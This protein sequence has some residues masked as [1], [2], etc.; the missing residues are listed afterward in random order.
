MVKTDQATH[1][2]RYRVFKFESSEARAKADTWLRK[3]AETG[4]V[5]DEKPDGLVGMAEGEGNILLNGGIDVMWSLICGDGTA[6]AY[7]ASHAR[8]GVG[9]GSD[10]E[11]ATQTSLQGTSTAFSTM[12]N[13]YPVYGSNQKAVFQASFDEDEANFTW[14]EWCVDNGTT[15]M[16]RK[17]EN[18]GTKTTGTWTLQVEITLS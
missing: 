14:N 1:Y 10:A 15:L 8:I 3:I 5:P 4:E 12:D 13:G 16:N 7:D 9:N 18:L 2:T 6:T 17:V 11:D